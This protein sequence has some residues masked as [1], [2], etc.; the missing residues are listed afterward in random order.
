LGLFPHS[1]VANIW[2]DAISLALL[3]AAGYYSYRA[4]VLSTFSIRF[5]AKIVSAILFLFFGIVY[6]QPLT[7]SATIHYLLL[8][9]V[10]LT[11]SSF[12]AL[13]AFLELRRRAKIRADRTVPS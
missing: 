6:M 13:S 4:A 8:T 2:D 1:V 3:V 9:A 12:N 7:F 10:F 11:L 5:S